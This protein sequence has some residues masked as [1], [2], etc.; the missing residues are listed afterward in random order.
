LQKTKTTR[1]PEENATAA[2]LKP[3]HFKPGQCANP[4]GRPKKKPIS[5]RYAEQIEVEAPREIAEQLGLPPHATMGDV[6]ARRMA[7]RAINSR[8]AVEASR[9]MREA[10]EGKAPQALD[11]KHSGEVTVT[12]IR[13][14][15]KRTAEEATA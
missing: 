15:R 4:G 10:V 12:I 9:E 3:Y 8:S 1:T 6:I 14:S 7:I 11:L 13:K 5:D 2:W